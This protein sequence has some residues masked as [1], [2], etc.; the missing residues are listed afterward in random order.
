[1]K[2]AV[3]VLALSIAV[4]ACGREGPLV[5]GA[6][7]SV[8]VT[9]GKGFCELATRLE[10]LASAELTR[11]GPQPTS[12]QTLATLKVFGET[13]LAE[14]RELERL[15]PEQLKIPLRAQRDFRRRLPTVTGRE[16]DVLLGLAV[17][18]G[19]RIK[20]YEVRLCAGRRPV[21]PTA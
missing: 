15:A 14:Y 4:T 11:L 19:T 6:A 16:R 5:T 18:N 21:L 8:P 1:V 20:R 17:A 10:R 2:R 13:H 12:D 9:A 7:Q 3:A